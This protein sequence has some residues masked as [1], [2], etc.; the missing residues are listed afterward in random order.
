MRVTR[1][2]LDVAS[3]RFVNAVLSAA[4]DLVLVLDGGA[5]VEY[6]N[7]AAE[8]VLGRPVEELVNRSLLDVVHPDDRTGLH[9]R[10][11]DAWLGGVDV[12]GVVRFRA[13]CAAGRWLSLEATGIERID[14]GGVAR[15]VAVV[16]D[17][18]DRV[19]AQ[20]LLDEAAARLEFATTHDPLTRLLTR[21]ALVDRLDSTLRTAD[22]PVALVMVKVLDGDELRD[23]YGVEEA[24]LIVRNLGWAMLAE[25]RPGDLV[26]T[27]GVGE[28]VIA[29]EPGRWGGDVDELT[30]RLYSLADEPLSSRRAP[31]DVRL[32][33]ATTTLRRGRTATGALDDLG[34]AV[35]WAGATGATG[36]VEFDD[37]LR[38]ELDD[39]RRLAR[40]VER[41]L[42]AGEFELHYQP[43]SDIRGGAV[44]GFE[45]LLRWNHPSRGQLEAGRFVPAVAD[46]ELIVALGE[47]VV[48]A[49]C[50]QLAQWQRRYTDRPPT[51]AINVSPRQLRRP[52]FADLVTGWLDSSGADPT[53]LCLDLSEPHRLGPIDGALAELRR[54]RELGVWIA[55]DDFGSGSSALHHLR[56]LRP[57]VVKVDRALVDQLGVDAGTTA[58]ARMAIELG[59]AFGATTIAEGVTTIE[60]HR[61]LLS[62]GC[63]S[64][65]G[66]LVA[67]ALP[68]R[69]AE[70]LLAD[71]SGPA[72]IDV[73]TRHAILRA[74]DRL[75][76]L[77]EGYRP[78]YDEVAAMSG[79]STVQ[80]RCAL[81]QRPD[82]AVAASPQEQ[83]AA[84]AADTPDPRRQ[85]GS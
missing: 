51:L 47:L 77:D 69:L 36:P 78:S 49:A 42:S 50:T 46:T 32:A 37:Q 83:G 40:D 35:R 66:F 15:I 1:A 23:R 60:Q 80:A 13:E 59:A 7:A 52:G 67:P 65:Q 25:A 72:V 73:K 30:H 31:V 82:P 61:L 58:I 70:H 34:A 44:S 75:G 21:R 64:I 55:L 27:D 14:D 2:P 85:L 19:E 38:I 76:D 74:H 29:A 12:A 84:A 39:R 43:I 28:F 56:A 10:L 62:M 16:R 8:S 3:P 33:V 9:D 63:D 24:Q 45:G 5:V 81:N 53:G 22:P 11:T 57:D 71:R 20:R 79:V 6:V 68:A 18:S 41:G 26:A 17:V 48:S 4:S 54:L